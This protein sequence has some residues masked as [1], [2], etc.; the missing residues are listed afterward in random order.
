[1]ASD[2]SDTDNP[3]VIDVGGTA[4]I[5]STWPPTVDGDD[6]KRGSVSA[7]VCVDMVCVCG[8]DVRLGTIQRSVICQGCGTEWRLE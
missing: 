2:S 5:D 1:M 4:S 7:N 6:L 8:N 3:R